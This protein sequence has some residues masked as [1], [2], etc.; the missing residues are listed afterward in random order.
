MLK[1]P[2]LRKQDFSSLLISLAAIYT[3]YKEDLKLGCSWGEITIIFTNLP[4]L[5]LLSF[6]EII[7]I[8]VYNYDHLLKLH[9]LVSF[10]ATF[11]SMSFI[12]SLSI[13]NHLTSKSKALSI[14]STP[15]VPYPCTLQTHEVTEQSDQTYH[16]SAFNKSLLA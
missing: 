15:A 6:Y 1:P 13:Q 5:H 2:K 9:L 10:L 8:L 3:V 7:I 4:L 14:A 12:D 11:H 16:L